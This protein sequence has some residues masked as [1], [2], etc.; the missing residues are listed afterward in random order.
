MDNA[1]IIPKSVI[2]FGSAEKVTY[3]KFGNAVVVAA[4]YSEV[5]KDYNYHLLEIEN[6]YL[7]DLR[8]NHL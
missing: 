3:Q 5:S 8:K 7:A 1:S 6:K 4:A 2:G